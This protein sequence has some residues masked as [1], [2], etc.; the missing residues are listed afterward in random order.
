MNLYNE[1]RNRQQSEFN[2][3]PMAFAYN[4]EQFV[5]GMRKLGLEPEETD[6]VVKISA[7]G[8]IRKKDSNDFSAMLKRHKSQMDKAI[9]EDKTG[10]G[11]IKDMFAYELA[12]HEYDY[13]GD[14]EDTLDALDLTIEKVNANPKLLKGL[15]L[16]L[17]RYSTW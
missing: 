4:K 6:K 5:D 11:F 13:T 3:F 10:A 9:A 16:A 1:L 2:S 15:K 17:R 12:N 14:L 7:G 8:F